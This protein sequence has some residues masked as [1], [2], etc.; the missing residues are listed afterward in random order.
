MMAS[1]IDLEDF[2]LGFALT[3]GM[4]ADRS[5]LLRCELVHQ[6]QNRIA[7]DFSFA[8]HMVEIDALDPGLAGDGVSGIIGNHADA[9]LRPGKRYF[10]V[11]IALHQCAIRKEFAHRLRPE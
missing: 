9:S 5:E 4:I 2:L 6:R 3:E 7:D 11:D 1:P 10:D 8:P